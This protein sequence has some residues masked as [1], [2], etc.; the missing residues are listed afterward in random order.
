M[1]MD[2]GMKGMGILMIAGLLVIT[3]V[4]ADTPGNESGYPAYADGYLLVKSIAS[5]DGTVQSLEHVH[6]GI[7]ATVTEDFTAEGIPGLSLVALPAN[8]TVQDATS[9]YT[10]KAGVLYAEPDYYRSISAVPTD[11]DFWRQWGLQNTG[12]VYRE[13]TTPGIAGADIRVTDG[14]NQTTSGNGTLVAVLDTGVDYQHPDLAA[15]IW[16]DNATGTHGYDALTGTLDPMDQNNHGTHCAGIIG[17]VANNGI[18]GSGVAWNATIMPVRWIDSN[19]YGKVSDEIN[20]ILWASHHGAKIFSCSYGFSSSSR[21]ERDVIANTSALFVFA[22]GNDDQNIDDSPQYP[23]SYGLPNMIVVASTTANDTRSSFSNYGNKNGSPREHR[24]P[25][26]SRP[27]EVTYSPVPVYLDP[28]T[29]L[30]NWSIGGNWTLD[31]TRFVSE[32]ASVHGHLGSGTFNTTNAPIV[33]APISGSINLSTISDPVVSYQVAMRG[34]FMLVSLEISKDGYLWSTVDTALI[35][36]NQDF[37]LK[38]AQIPDK[39]KNMTVG[40]RFVA[41]GWNADVNID[42]LSVSDGYGTLKEPKWGYLSGTS[43]AT[44]MVAGVATLLSGYDPT[45]SVDQIRNA[46]LTT[47]DPKQDLNNT[48]SNRGRNKLY[49]CSVC[50]TEFHRTN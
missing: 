28:F 50:P 10:G 15:N 42:D 46:I 30:G 7:G 14:W 45:A 3:A 43:M 13:N 17:A 47:T 2:W 35:S 34:T 19:G 16:T 31:T 12:Q 38:Q 18:G 23:A 29:T 6:T 8:M 21:A 49:R 33:L 36:S 24:A 4:T 9:Y 11:P 5:Q 40:F 20:A 1:G 48:T 32:P 22:A 27:S 26:S 44:P 25:M 41:E 39:F 37:M